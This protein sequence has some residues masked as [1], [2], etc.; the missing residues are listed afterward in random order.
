ATNQTGLQEFIQH[1]GFDP[2]KDVTEILAASVGNPSAPSGIL[3]VK[4]NFNLS[5]L[6]A[7]LQN[8]KNVTV[9]NYGPATLITTGGE[10]K[11][12]HGVAFLNGTIAIAGDLT[13]VKAAVD[14]SG[15]VNA[16]AP[17]LAAQV[18]TLSSTYDAW[19]VSIASLGALI[20]GGIAGNANTAQPLQL[21]K[22]IQSANSGVK[23]GANV[24]FAAQ[25][26]A[27]TPANATSLADVIKMIAGLAAM[28]ATSQ[29]S[30]AAPLAAVL[31]TVQIT[32]DGATVNIAATVPETQIETILNAANVKH[33][34][35]GARRM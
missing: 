10:V 14:R 7:S 29:N 16:V 34:A 33:A 2:T 26:V 31:Q 5:T 19:S 23:F 28:S 20:P 1:A 18:Q 27:D 13:S 11:I 8:E 30:P 3:L 32:T 22:N 12:P 25:A 9:T 21:V 24:Q 6:L 17:A 35:V 15:S 4:G